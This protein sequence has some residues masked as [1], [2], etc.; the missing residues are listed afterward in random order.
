VN[1]DRKQLQKHL[2]ELVVKI[3]PRVM[4]SREDQAAIDY[5]VGLLDKWNVKTRL[6]EFQ[7]PCW[8]HEKTSLRIAGTSR[9]LTA[10]ACQYS[11][12]CDLVGEVVHLESLNMVN[13]DPVRDRVCLIPAG[14][15]KIVTDLNIVAL[16][17]Q[18]R[19][20]KALIVDRQHVRPN[21]YDGKIVREPDLRRMPVVCAS[22]TS[23]KKI[24][25]ERRPVRLRIEA[26][27]FE[28]A[29]CNIEATIPGKGDGRVF[30]TAHRDTGAGAPGAT[31]A[32]G[33]LAIALEIARA[34]AAEQP[35]Y[36]TRILFTGAHERLGMGAVHYAA[37]HELLLADARQLVN[38]D[39]IGAKTSS[40][41][42]SV[43]GDEEYA[44]RL[45]VFARA[46]QPLK[47]AAKDGL[48]GDVRPFADRGVNA[49]WLR[50]PPK[51]H[52]YRVGH[53]QFDDMNAI[54]IAN[55]EQI[56][57]MALDLVVLG[58]D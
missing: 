30:V 24:L 56:G 58:L 26:Y 13:N 8:Q 14:V 12:P 47:L 25:K 48:G 16:A 55:V 54:A 27:Y 50:Q 45:K 19:G 4:G 33:G 22:H 36:E 18:A 11:E 53:T 31:D 38:L 44:K 21:A 49:T 5:I 3:G 51:D 40:P 2:N 15:G 57:R 1:M 20:A 10:H 7:S 6:H 35:P 52:R 9:D 46:H 43:E 39:G 29:T 41:V 17:L 32:T 37:D 23:A 34:L 42:A 28:G